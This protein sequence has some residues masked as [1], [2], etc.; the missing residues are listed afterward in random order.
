MLIPQKMGLPNSYFNGIL[1]GISNI[2][3]Q[4]IMLCTFHLFSRKFYHYVHISG[5]VLSSIILLILSLEFDSNNFTSN[6]IES[7]LSGISNFY[8]MI[9]VYMYTNWAI[10]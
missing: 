2:V 4:I 7:I 5:M 10:V 6:L 8:W 1:I 3:A 9:S